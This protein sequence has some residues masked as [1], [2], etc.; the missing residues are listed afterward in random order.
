MNLDYNYITFI[1]TLFIDLDSVGLSKYTY[2]TS[3]VLQFAHDYRSYLFAKQ[4]IPI[5]SG[6][7]EDAEEDETINNNMAGL[8][9][10]L[11]SLVILYIFKQSSGCN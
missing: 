1:F 10:L 8:C 3:L 7:T 4:A 9:I 2:L 5:S 6:P 11:K